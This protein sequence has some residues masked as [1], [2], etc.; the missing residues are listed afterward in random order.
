MLVVAALIISV[1]ACSIQPLQ[2][3][4]T[5]A[6]DWNNVNFNELGNE[7]LVYVGEEY[8]V[9]FQVIEKETFDIYT[10]IIGQFIG[11][12]FDGKNLAATTLNMPLE[13]NHVYKARATLIPDPQFGKRF[14]IFEAEDLGER[15]VPRKQPGDTTDPRFET[16]TEQQARVR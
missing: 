12:T 13:L 6:V 16:T 10:N 11:G 14:F 9:T 15:T 4:Q 2:N 1:L 7:D 8:V 5:C 3:F